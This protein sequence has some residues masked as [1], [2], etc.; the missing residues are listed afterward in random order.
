[1]G[2]TLAIFQMLGIIPVVKLLI[3]ILFRGRATLSPHRSI[4]AEIPTEPVALFVLSLHIHG[5]ISLVDIG[6]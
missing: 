6:S 4:W 1:M 3:N 2:V 5:L